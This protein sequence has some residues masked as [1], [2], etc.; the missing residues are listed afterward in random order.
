MKK[1][2]I[3]KINKFFFKRLK[4][5]F[6]EFI[7]NSNGTNK[8][9]DNLIKFNVNNLTKN[10]LNLIGDSKKTEKL[11]LEKLNIDQNIEIKLYELFSKHH[12][13]KHY[14]GYQKLYAHV[15]SNLQKVNN[16]LE[17][18]IGTNNSKTVSNMGRDGSP[19]ASLRAFSEF[20][21][22]TKIYGADI[23]RD[24][25]FEEN[26]IKTFF[27]DQNDLESYDNPIIKNIKFDLIIDDGLHMQ[28]SNL[29]TLKFA[30]NKL[31]DNGI[32]IIEDVTEN[33]LNTWFIARAL[34][35]KNFQLKIIECLDNYAILVNNQ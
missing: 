21:P 12:S 7:P 6:E 24:I 9:I 33:T 34:L 20:L 2:L 14:H 18:G 23:D 26:N 17:I 1:K 25:L 13:D 8:Q 3:N 10:L 28:S 22:N 30:L 31:E 4:F 29:N 16:L 19:G 32:L 5:N 15:F 11:K 35:K 27:L